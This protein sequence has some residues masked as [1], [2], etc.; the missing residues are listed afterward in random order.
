MS[1]G[2]PG[3]AGNTGNAVH[4]VGSVGSASASAAS[5]EDAA[6]RSRGRGEM[7]SSGLTPE[8]MLRRRFVRVR[9]EERQEVEPTM[10]ALDL[11]EL[12]DEQLNDAVTLASSVAS[13]AT[14]REERAAARILAQIFS[15]ALSGVQNSWLHWSVV[16]S[17]AENA[18]GR[19]ARRSFVQFLQERRP[20]LLE[21]RDWVEC[22]GTQG[23]AR[24]AGVR[25]AGDTAEEQQVRGQQEREREDRRH[26]LLRANA[27]LVLATQ[28]AG[29]LRTALCRLLQNGILGLASVCADIPRLL[30]LQAEYRRAVPALQVLQERLGQLEEVLDGGAPRGALDLRPFASPF[31][32]GQVVVP[33]VA[34]D[35][36][37]TAWVRGR[38]DDLLEWQHQ[39]AQ[40]VQFRESV[41]G[42]AVDFGQDM[43][44]L[45]A[46]LARRLARADAQADSDSYEDEGEGEDDRDEDP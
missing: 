22:R 4:G 20:E 21:G 46:P 14:R 17:V 45:P 16:R 7:G 38:A 30:A 3:N 28:F 5:Q 9:E 15:A 12:S 18:R 33:R 10:A 35:P 26:L 42:E 23:L 34:P 40:L 41:T 39:V 36:S 44:A 37:V 13:S 11:R 25:F 2:L 27:A 1:S 43:S 32:A 24:F 29:G 19:D 8:T 6:G 31:A